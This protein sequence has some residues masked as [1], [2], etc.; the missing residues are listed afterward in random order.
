MSGRQAFR[1]V[2]PTGDGDR[3]KLRAG[4]NGED[5]VEVFA[6]RT[7]DPAWSAAMR[8]L[9]QPQGQ[10]VVD[11]G[12]GT[13]TAA[14]GWL[15]LGAASV[16][17]IDRSARMI[18]AARRTTPPTAGLSFLVGD[19]QRTGLPAGEADLVFTRAVLHHLPSFRGLL[20]EA[21]RI[22][23]PRGHLLIQ[24][25]TPQDVRFPGTETFI[26]G[27][28]LDRFPGLLAVE[29]ARRIRSED[30]VAALEDAGFEEPEISNLWEIRQVHADLESLT[31]DLW[32]RRTRSSIGQLTPHEFEQL[33]DHLRHVLP[34]GRP[35]VE[36]DRWTLWWA[37][38]PM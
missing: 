12:C 32:A 9:A 35:I 20:D 21:N 29:D 10:R 16:V 36:Q 28:I 5:Q 25:R 8:E 37:R 11:L 3:V 34:E 2:I 13:G 27:H 22:L 19:A 4:S 17:G 26:R 6:R 23:A 38:K 1:I 15:D 14:R 24:D 7:L 18:E 31:R 33:V 30:V